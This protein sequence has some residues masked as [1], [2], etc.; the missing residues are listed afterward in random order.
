MICRLFHVTLG[1][2]SIKHQISMWD[3][4]DIETI[5]NISH[6]RQFNASSVEN[7]GF[8]RV[9]ESRRHSQIRVLRE[10]S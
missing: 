2:N 8:M 6:D 10:A 4:A 5:Q 9:A 1:P 7:H 3:T